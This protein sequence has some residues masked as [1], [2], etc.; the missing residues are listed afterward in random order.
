MRRLALVGVLVAV[1]VA[2]MGASVARADPTALCNGQQCIN[3]IWYTGPVSVTWDLNGGSNGGGCAPQNYTADTNQSDLLN[4]PM[5]DWPVWTYCNDTT[6]GVLRYY[7]IRVETSSPTATVTPNRPTDSGG[8]YNHPVAGATSASSF[9]GIASCTS[10]TYAGPATTSATVAATCLDNAG[11]SVTVTS[12]P[13][14]YDATPPTLTAAAD[15]GDQN[16]AL[17]WR[18]AGDVAPVA[19]VQVT[20]RDAANTAGIATVYSGNGSAFDNTHLENGVRYTY[21]ITARDQAGNVAVRTITA[22]PGPRLLGPAPDAHLTAPPMLSWTSVPRADYY[23]V[24]L[25]RDGKMVKVLSRWPDRAGLQLRRTW[26]FNGRRYRLRPGKYRWYVWPGF[27][28]RSAG[29]YGQLIGSGTFVVT[30]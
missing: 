8:W 23:N 15:P 9:S 3:G 30:R 11:K 13:F 28:H 2:L 27:G 21:T 17:S 12:A 29:R 22:T 19:S 4:E 26:R 5:S 20:R 18:A 10:T 14:S 7:F 24:Q 25:F 16:I 6:T 1:A